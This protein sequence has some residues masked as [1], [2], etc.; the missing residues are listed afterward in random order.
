MTEKYFLKA[1]YQK[2]WQEVTKEEWIQ[3]ER[4]AGFRPKCASTDPEY[5][6]TCATSGFGGNGVSGKIRFSEE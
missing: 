5:M 2:N 1:D 6:T 4:S 3:A